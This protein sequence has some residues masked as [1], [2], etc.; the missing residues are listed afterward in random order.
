MAARGRRGFGLGLKLCGR[1]GSLG[2]VDVCWKASL[3][4]RKLTSAEVV[5]M[6]LGISKQVHN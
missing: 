6:S 2:F 3:S 1:S 4:R 5:L